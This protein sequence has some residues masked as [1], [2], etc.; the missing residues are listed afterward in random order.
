MVER[1]DLGD[2]E[3]DSAAT[4]GRWIDDTANVAAAAR[5]V[6]VAPPLRPPPRPPCVR[7]ME[8]ESGGRDDKGD[9]D[10]DNWDWDDVGENEEGEEDAVAAPETAAATAAAVTA[11]EVN[12]CAT[13]VDTDDD[14]ARSGYVGDGAPPIRSAGDEG[15][16][17]GSDGGVYDGGGRGDGGP[18]IQPEVT[19]DSPASA[20]VARSV[21]A[22][23][24]QSRE[25]DGRRSV[26]YA[27]RG[28]SGPA[29]ADGRSRGGVAVCG[30]GKDL[31]FFGGTAQLALRPDAMFR[32][33]LHPGVA[34][35]SLPTFDANVGPAALVHQESRT[36]SGYDTGGSKRGSGDNGFDGGEAAA[37]A[38]D[39]AEVLPPTVVLDSC[40]VAPLRE[41]CR[42]ASSSCLEVFTEELGIAKLAGWCVCGCFVYL[43][44]CAFL[45]SCF[46]VCTVNIIY[47][48][49]CLG[50]FCFFVRTW[51][52]VLFMTFTNMV[53]PPFCGCLFHCCFF[54][55]PLFLPLLLPA[56]A[57]RCAE[58]GLPVP[59]RGQERQ[60]PIAISGGVVQSPRGVAV[61][62]RWSHPLWRR[63]S[64]LSGRFGRG[65]GA[66]YPRVPSGRRFFREGP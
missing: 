27:G 35:P 2:E 65:G 64:K 24:V 45:R 66:R 32:R 36:A 26:E 15:D 62:V 31:G 44:V 1:V 42:L 60:S 29:G 63:R 21:P 33:A 53:A 48:F 9:D 43:C 6:T 23:E 47:S 59:R 30:V 52:P 4:S 18:A 40:L 49:F 34:P 28:S 22:S 13:E 19:T 46:P 57:L 11:T 38:E 3:G 58:R 25:P 51:L 7:W 20:V 41:H 56:A 61:V 8:A 14:G 39:V 12:A 5:V 10:G 54:F 37:A 50:R 16:D 17:D 55:P